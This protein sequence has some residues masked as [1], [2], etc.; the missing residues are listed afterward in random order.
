MVRYTELDN[1]LSFLELEK[2]VL[3]SGHIEAKK[4]YDKLKNKY[5]NKKYID[6]YN[7]WYLKNLLHQAYDLKKPRA[8]IEVKR[9]EKIE[10]VR[11]LF[12]DI[13]KQWGEAHA[14]EMVKKWHGR[15]MLEIILTENVCRFER[16][17]L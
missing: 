6:L 1:Y 14:K 9:R 16:I 2:K 5:S 15:K 3:K 12:S 7:D 10:Q 13:K 4:L 8:I 17:R 11:K